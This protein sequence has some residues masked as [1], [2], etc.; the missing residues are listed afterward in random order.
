MDEITL[1]FKENKESWENNQQDI[2][3]IFHILTGMAD[4]FVLVC[5]NASLGKVIND[6]REQLRQQM[7][8]YLKQNSHLVQNNATPVNHLSKVGNRTIRT[9]S[10]NYR[11]HSKR[12]LKGGKERKM[13]LENIT[14]SRKTKPD[15]ENYEISDNNIDTDNAIVKYKGDNFEISSLCSYRAQIIE[16]LEKTDFPWRNLVKKSIRA[17][18]SLRK[19]QPRESY[20]LKH[21]AAG[22]LL[23]S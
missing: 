10:S 12:L 20:P 16:T 21:L 13:F 22:K 19:R 6:G 23:V 7:M 4:T 9:A 11:I 14:P 1:G 8:N 3:Y 5:E 17:I 2:R 15:S 18:D